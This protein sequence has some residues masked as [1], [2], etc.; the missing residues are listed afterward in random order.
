MGKKFTY[1]ILIFLFGLNLSLMYYLHRI[2]TVYADERDTMQHQIETLQVKNSLLEDD[3]IL[4][5]AGMYKLPADLILYAESGDSL[6]LSNV[7][8]QKK[9]VVFRYSFL[10]CRP[11]VDSVMAYLSDFIKENEKDLEVIL[12]AT[13]SQPRDLR[14]F[15]RSNQLFTQ[16]Y[17]IKSLNLPVEELDV[18]YLFLLDENLTV[19]DLFIPRKEMP[20][21]LKRYLKKI[22]S[23][24]RAQEARKENK[25]QNE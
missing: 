17:T 8:K 7:K 11:C 20:Y 6:D 1:F 10:H 9:T 25:M 5:G 22:S 15:K 12:L 24:M 2:N 16:V 14:T 13:Y 23:G 18:P 4:S 19:V 3:L 21:L